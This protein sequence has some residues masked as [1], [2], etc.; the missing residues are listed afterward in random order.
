MIDQATIISD[1]L[2]LFT[3]IDPI[4]TLSIFVGLTASLS[5]KERAKVAFRAIGYSALILIFAV[6]LGQVALGSMGIELAS[7]ELAGGII[8]F[9][10]G[11]QMVFGTG[12]ADS[13]AKQEEGHDVAVFPLAMP[14]IASPGSIL[15]AVMLTDNREHTAA[16]QAVTAGLLLL[17][18]AITLVILLQASRVFSILGKAGTNL[19]VRVMG[20]VL[21][22]VAVEMIIEAFVEIIPQLNGG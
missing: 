9:L 15:A 10:F 19:V 3:P 12:A 22:S 18:L 5:D 8:F 16:Q 21:A 1:F 4:G 7:F 13:N 6:V 11:L 14:S 2:T 17:V 20:L